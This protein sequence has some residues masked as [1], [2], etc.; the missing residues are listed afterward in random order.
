MC[1]KDFPGGTG[2]KNL[3]AIAEMQIQCL[4]QE[5]SLK[6]EMTTHSSILAGESHGQRRLGVY[7]PW[8]CKRV[9]QD[10]AIKKQ[11]KIANVF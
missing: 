4:G 8:G 2:L 10:W 11:Q 5:D 3:P 7:S 6:K 1:F 9:G